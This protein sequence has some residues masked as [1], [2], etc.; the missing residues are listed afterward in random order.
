MTKQILNQRYVGNRETR[1]YD[2]RAT[3]DFDETRVSDERAK[4]L[5][6][7]FLRDIVND[8]NSL[9]IVEANKQ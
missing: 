6:V 8:P 7:E 4:E 1:T 3:M 9:F 2:I 5:Y